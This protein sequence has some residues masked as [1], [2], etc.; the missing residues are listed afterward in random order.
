MTNEQKTLRATGHPLRAQSMPYVIPALA[1]SIM[2][3]ASLLPWL[4]DPLGSVY[5]AWAIPLDIGWHLRS[6][7][8]N[9]GLLCMCCALASFLLAY[10]QWRQSVGSLLSRRPIAK[11]PGKNQPP[12][13]WHLLATI[14]CLTPLLLFLLQYLYIDIHSVD[15]LAQH[16]LQ[17]L[18]IQQ[19]MG[20]KLAD[21]PIQLQPFQMDITTLQ[22]RM[23]L[24]TNQ[25]A[26]GLAGPLLSAWLLVGYLP[27]A[28]QSHSASK[29]ESNINLLEGELAS[30]LPANRVATGNDP[31]GSRPGAWSGMGEGYIAGIRGWASALSPGGFAH[32]RATLARRQQLIR[33][34][35]AILIVLIACLLMR[36]P[37]AAISES[38]ARS[39]LATGDYA[40][41]IWW[42]KV[43]RRLNPE[44]AQMRSYHEEMGQ[45]WYFTHPG[46]S[47]NDSH[48]YLASVYRSQGDY[49]NAY[50]ELLE[51]W[52]L[53]QKA[54]WIK[55][56]LGLTVALLAENLPQKVNGTTLPESDQEV[57]A[58][59]WLQMLAHV[60]NANLYSQYYMGR[61]QYDKHDYAAC[62]RQMNTVLR[63]SHNSDIRSSAYTYIAL[64]MRG[65][66]DIDG[67]RHLLLKAIE[68]DPYYHNNTAREEL[69]G[70]H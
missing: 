38:Q 24:L 14:F 56:E 17:L 55:D 65:E 61:I 62:I 7:I 46:A 16:K 50:Q 13:S 5:T 47:N 33:T 57:A 63:L 30:R 64:S 27:S 20:Y 29:D 26:A 1:G 19:H 22:G 58:L 9:Y 69:S 68:L 39:Q 28:S 11:T 70:L 34:A 42:L 49:L 12:I 53:D 52:N 15:T 45:V 10:Q 21:Q 32:L 2:L 67:A 8:V 54:S 31:G 3:A 23:V 35:S 25:V 48:L 66:G 51:A 59:T 43:A 44:L 40:S 6:H 37:L 18:L 41:A 36:A 60:D 4:N